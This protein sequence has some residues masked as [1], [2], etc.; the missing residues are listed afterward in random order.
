MRDFLPD[1]VRRRR[2]VMG[3]IA[4]VYQQY[5]FEPI[6]TPS[7]E[8]LETLQGKYGEEGDRLIFKILKRGEGAETGQADLALRYDL[9]VPLARV[10]AEY[11]S[12]LPKFFKRY[13]M[14]P[15]W[16]ADRPQRGRFREFYQCDV[17]AIGSKSMVV[18][19][20]LLS[21]AS[22]VLA[23]LG[24]ADFTIRLNHR[25]VLAGMLDAGGVPATLHNDAL[26]ALDK[27]DKIGRDGVAGEFAAR[28]IP[29]AGASL[30][31]EF[32]ATLRASAEQSDR[33]PG[34]FNRET[35][36]R[37]SGLVVGDG[38]AGVAQLQEIV[39]LSDT[40]ENTHVHAPSAIK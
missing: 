36:A 31:L 21:A 27:L 24:F 3:V 13:Q 15:V 30:L 9:T 29:F 23:R 17:D 11:R 32:F 34:R 8:N 39:R 12:Q 28:G 19:A 25:R 22:D 16:R 18:E 38:A 33:D 20:E 5:G 1:D 4:E 14:Q 2:Y 7:V 37:L 26:V 40:T 10:V 35:L 6:E